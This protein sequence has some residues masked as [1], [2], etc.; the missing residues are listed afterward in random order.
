M[1][2]IHKVV[3]LNKPLKIPLPIVGSFT[4][5][6]WAL[7]AVSVGIGFLIATRVI[8][9]DWKIGNNMPVSV[10]SF[11]L[12]IMGAVVFIFACRLK[13]LAWWRNLLLYRL[14]LNSVE[15]H[16]RTDPGIEYP[17]PSI[18]DDQKGKDDFYVKGDD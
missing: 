17:D 12:T 13:P 2:R 18:T 11:V 14:G 16:P 8:P 5:F 15:L 7:L 3:I 9:P 10:L 4:P 6:Q 1:S